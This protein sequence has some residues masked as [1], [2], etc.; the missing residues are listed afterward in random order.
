[1]TLSGAG[2][3]SRLSMAFLLLLGSQPRPLTS[4]GPARI[5]PPSRRRWGS[6]AGLRPFKAGSLPEHLSAQ[7]HA[8]RRWIDRGRIDDPDLID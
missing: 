2:R 7:G 3:G 8:A 1:M 5:T 6:L 4:G